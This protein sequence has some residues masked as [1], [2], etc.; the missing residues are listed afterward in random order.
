VNHAI[1]AD[2]CR[3]QCALGRFK[4]R[5]LEVQL[6]FGVSAFHSSKC[7]TIEGVDR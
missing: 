6:E 5:I 1:I 2:I 7:K 3:C 4:K